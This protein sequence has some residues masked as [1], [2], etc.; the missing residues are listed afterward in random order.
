MFKSLKQNNN[1]TNILLILS[2]KTHFKEMKGLYFFVP[3]PGKVYIPK[4]GP[5]NS[6]LSKALVTQPS[7]L[8]L[9]SDVTP[10]THF[11]KCQFW[12]FVILETNKPHE[13]IVVRKEH[14]K[15]S[16]KR[17]GP[18]NGRDFCDMFSKSLKEAKTRVTSMPEEEQPVVCICVCLGMFWFD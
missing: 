8:H 5:V 1:Q 6:Q 3:F 2:W 7:P 15:G 16:V 13:T 18:I 17:E 9:L 14:D 12:V 4:Y 10:K 11:D